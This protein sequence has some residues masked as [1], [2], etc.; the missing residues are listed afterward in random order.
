MSPHPRSTESETLGVGLS[1]WFKEPSR[2]FCCFLE[3]DISKPKHYWALTTCC[4]DCEF[5]RCYYFIIIHGRTLK[6]RGMNFP[7]YFQDCWIIC[8]DNGL[9]FKKKKKKCQHS[10]CKLKIRKQ[11][12]SHKERIVIISQSRTKIN[13]AHGF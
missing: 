3:F 9:L 7:A 2:W 6:N 4:I 8:K 5:H 11:F 13:Y 12:I 10:S 1:V